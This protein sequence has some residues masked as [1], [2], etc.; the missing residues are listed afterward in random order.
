MRYRLEQNILFTLLQNNP[1]KYTDEEPNCPG[2]VILVNHSYLASCNVLKYSETECYINDTFG[3]YKIKPDKK[4][5]FGERLYSINVYLHELFKMNNSN[6]MLKH[7]DILN[8]PIFV[9]ITKRQQFLNEELEK[10]MKKFKF[11]N[12]IKSMKIEWL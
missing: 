7:D 9:N 3:V 1:V 12:L 10:Y 8:I 11:N 5:D 4:K 6:V 2:D